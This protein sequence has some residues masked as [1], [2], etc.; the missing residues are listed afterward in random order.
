MKPEKKKIKMLSR[1]CVG[2]EAGLNKQRRAA[3]VRDSSPTQN[4]ASLFLHF[5][6]NKKEAEICFPLANKEKNVV[7]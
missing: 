6:G 5:L 1:K 3:L 7:A 2:E 4:S